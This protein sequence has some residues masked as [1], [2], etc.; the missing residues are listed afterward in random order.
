[1]TSA[2]VVAE[3]LVGGKVNA[4]GGNYLVPCPAHEDSSPSLS[5]CDGDRGLMVHCFAGCKAKDVF[6]AI[7][8]KLGKQIGDERVAPEPVKGS[9]EYGRRQ[10][11]KAAWLWSQRKPIAGTI[12]EKYLRGR[13]ITCA[14][15]ATLGF[16][17][18]KKSEHHPAMIAAF[19]TVD[20]P[21]PGL[22]G[23]PRHVASVHLTLLR[24]DGSDK[25]DVEKPKLMVGSSR[26]PIVL[27]PPNDLLGL[28]ISEGIE[29][30]LTEHL[31]TGVGAWAAGAAGRMPN[32]ADLVPSYIEAVTIL[33]H[34]D[35]AGRRGARDL[36][37]TLDRRG[38][39]VT[40]EGL[41]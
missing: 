15:P 40:I 19:A 4:R 24:P 14:L 5:L 16:L 17:P 37:V 25:A 6:E 20:E 7:R 33:A 26:L 18:P 38:T 11:E 31:S 1:M 32:L 13:G 36:A 41:S 21:E 39:Q 2:A 8:K 3:K 34:N 10:H 12:A 23:K 35:D 30:A 9:S 28:A 22:L 29:D 27:A